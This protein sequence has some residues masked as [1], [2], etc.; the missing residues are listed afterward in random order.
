[1]DVSLKS[2]LVIEDT[3]H[4][5][6]DTSLKFPSKKKQQYCKK[7]VIYYFILYIIIFNKTKMND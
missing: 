1:M 2:T 7:Q 6:H 4:S 5:V 3:N